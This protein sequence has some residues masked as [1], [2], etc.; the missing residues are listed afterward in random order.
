[1]SKEIR[2][3]EEKSAIF[4]KRVE[5]AIKN[6]RKRNING[7]YVRNRQEALSTMLEMIPVDATVARG[8][9]LTVTQIGIIPELRKRNQKEVLDPYEEDDA[10]DW[11]VE[12]ELAEKMRHDGLRA[13]VFLA[14]TN[15]VTLDGKLV[16]IDG[17]GNRVSGMIFG[18]KKVIV[19]VGVN[20]IVKNADAGIER[21]KEI[22]PVLIKWHTMKHSMPYQDVPCVKTGVCIDCT[23]EWKA[24]N[25]ITIIQGSQ[26]RHKDRI[27]VIFI[28][29]EMGL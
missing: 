25:Y 8:N 24:C 22:T 17:H 5:L 7:L 29:E 18:P 11:A 13:D 4:E 15:A 28:G 1:M 12:W 9:S 21:I 16:N 19:A 26:L 14:G 20:K 3:V 6:L 10:G 27:N 2:P 23:H